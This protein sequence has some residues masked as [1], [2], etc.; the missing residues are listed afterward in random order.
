[1]YTHADGVSISLQT[2]NA[3]L[4]GLG[5]GDGIVEGLL[6]SVLAD[7]GLSL[8]NSE[9]DLA[10]YPN[11]FRGINPGQFPRSSNDG[12]QLVDGGEA[13]DIVCKVSELT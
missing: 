8:R 13:S 1:M 11:S 2:A 12:L 7:A 4:L 5:D 3:T 10:I 9:D 6:D